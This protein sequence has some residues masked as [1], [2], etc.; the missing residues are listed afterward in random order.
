M[1]QPINTDY[2]AFTEIWSYPRGKSMVDLFLKHNK[3]VSLHS[4]DK[5]GLGLVLHQVRQLMQ[6][7]TP[8]ALIMLSTL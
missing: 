7:N 5:W 1:P 4:A 3:N 6:W 8:K 2:L